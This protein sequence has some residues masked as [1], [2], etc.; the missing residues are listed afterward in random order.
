MDDYGPQPLADA[1]ASPPEDLRQQ[2]NRRRREASAAA[3]GRRIEV[4][5]LRKRGLTY[6]QI[7][8]Q[9]GLSHGQIQRDYAQALKDH[10]TPVADELRDLEGMRLDEL[11]AGHWEKAIG[12]DKDASMICLQIMARR[13]RLWGLDEPKKIDMT[14][15]LTRIAEE[16]D[17]DP[18][19]M[20]AEAM[21]VIREA[22]L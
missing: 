8:A 13:A 11:Q 7:A 1:D 5:D 3:S 19:E 22:G 15:M 18:E 14:A 9:Y 6:R 17:L 10:A 12:G 4:M 16:A 21:E 20:I 2:R